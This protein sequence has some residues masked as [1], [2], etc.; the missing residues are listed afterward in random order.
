MVAATNSASSRSVSPSNATM[1]SPAA[2]SVN[3]RLSRRS[4]LRAMMALAARRMLPVE[5]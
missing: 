4:V 1:G 3:R 5:R 2:A